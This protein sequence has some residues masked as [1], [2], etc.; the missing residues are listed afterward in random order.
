MKH[1]KSL[2]DLSKDDIKKIFDLASLFTDQSQLPVNSESLLK[3]KTIVN[4]FFENSTRTRSSFELA[5]KRLGANVIN[6]NIDASST[7]KGETLADTISNLEAM[8]PDLFIIRHPSSGAIDFITHHLKSDTK[9]IN[10]GD[11]CHQHPTQGLLDL[12]TISQYKP[13]LLN[14]RIAIVG[15]LLHSRVARSQILA[16]KKMGV[17]EI[18]VIGPK[19][20][21]PKNIEKLGVSVFHS[22]EEGINK[23]D[24]IIML[25]LQTERMQSV[26]LP[27]K[28]EYH[29]FYGL[30]KQRLKLAKAD[31]LVLHPGPINRGVEISSEVADG[32]HSLILQ[33]VTLGIAI[34][35]AIMVTLLNPRAFA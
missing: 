5:A 6:F 3:N 14:L 31:V 34:R 16:F 32:P 23:A 15:D 9:V 24:V 13:D 20:L 18:R 27:S 11:G 7:K 26:F 25:R 19:T 29:R 28:R 12:F 4:L 1:L 10:A 30:T 33:Q 21:I 8:S 22:L 2:A 35:M 17:G